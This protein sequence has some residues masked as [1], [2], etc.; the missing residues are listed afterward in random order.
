MAAE[1]N[2]QDGQ[3]GSHIETIRQGAV[4]QHPL[5]GASAFGTTSPV[6]KAL[7]KAYRA[8]SLASVAR[9]EGHS[10]GATLSAASAIAASGHYKLEM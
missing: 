3:F 10:P 2:L 9:G 5:P 1:D 7:G 6:D 4:S 8:K